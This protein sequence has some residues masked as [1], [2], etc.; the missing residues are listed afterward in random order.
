MSKIAYHGP[1]ARTPAHQMCDKDTILLDLWQVHQAYDKS[2]RPPG[3][4]QGCHTT[5]SEKLI[6]AH[7][8]CDKE[9]RQRQGHQTTSPV[10]RTPDPLWLWQRPLT[11]GPAARTPGHQVVAR[12]KWSRPVKRIPDHLAYDKESLL[13]YPAGNSK[14]YLMCIHYFLLY[15]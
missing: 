8:T 11:S 1:V 15:L 10:T 2:T 6:L 12:I 13:I 4:W 9:T 3:L 14:F 7:Q 5:G